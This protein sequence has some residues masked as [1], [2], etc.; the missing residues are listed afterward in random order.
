MGILDLIGRY[1]NTDKSSVLHGYLEK[2]EKYLPFNRSDRIK[3]LEIGVLD[4]GSLKTWSDYFFKAK[5][6]GIDINPDCKL[7]EA[8]MIS[9][10]IGSQTDDDF[11]DTVISK[12]QQ[13]D[14]ILDDGS[15]INKDVIHTFYRLF[16]YLKSGGV[17]IVEDTCTSYWK[18]YGG[19]IGDGTMIEFFKGIIDEVNFFGELVDSETPHSRNDSALLERFSIFSDSYIGTQIESI[20]FLNSIIIITKR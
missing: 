8:N 7:H 5:V 2:Y 17:Y 15:H 6:V 3:I 10:E 11:L 16:P 13:F 14:F 18:D 12:Y 9:V 4:G 20:N 19:G 1:R